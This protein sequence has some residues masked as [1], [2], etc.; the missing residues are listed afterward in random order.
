MT[1][2]TA[3]TTALQA[4]AWIASDEDLLLALLERTGASGD[5]LRASAA[6]PEFLGAVMDFLLENEQILTDFCEQNDF[7]PET[8]KQV[9]QA[10]PGAAPEW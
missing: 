6:D 8:P 10:L 9:R 7:P 3:Q 1:P 2:E 5:D 4:L